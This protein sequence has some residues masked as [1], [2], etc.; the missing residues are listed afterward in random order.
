MPDK[1]AMDACDFTN[2]QVLAGEDESGYSY[3]FPEGAS[4]VYFS[5]SI[6]LHCQNG[7]VLAVAA[8][9]GDDPHGSEDLHS[10]HEPEE[11]DHSEGDGHDHDHGGSGYGRKL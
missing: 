9:T 5:C 11:D 6:D 2:A 1:A 7:Q 4:A 3:S 8:H 10:G